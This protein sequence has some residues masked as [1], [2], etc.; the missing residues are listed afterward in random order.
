[1]FELL[2]D[3]QSLMANDDWLELPIEEFNDNE[4][5]FLW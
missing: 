5:G 3:L 4:D 1:L 2:D